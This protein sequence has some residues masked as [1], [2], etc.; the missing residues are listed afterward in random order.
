MLK[1]LH[2]LILLQFLDT[3]FSVEL[4]L[5]VQSLAKLGLLF[6]SSVAPLSVQTLP[7]F[8]GLFF[9]RFVC[10]SS[11]LLDDC[12]LYYTYMFLGRAKTRARIFIVYSF[13]MFTY[14]LCA[15][16][17]MRPHTQQYLIQLPY[18]LC[19][20]FLSLFFW[21]MHNSIFHSTF[22]DS[23]IFMRRR[24]THTHQPTDSFAHLHYIGP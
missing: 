4:F 13:D 11:V 8:F 19:L 24:I 2:L 3:E 23:C 10:F 7:V 5:S 21:P 22:S 15:L 9:I 17:T 12:A 18:V 14:V 16:F 20:F 1:L 6:F